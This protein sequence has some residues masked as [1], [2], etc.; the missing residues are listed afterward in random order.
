MIVTTRSTK[1]P[2]HDMPSALSHSRISHT[3][4]AR[5]PLHLPCLPSFMAAAEDGMPATLSPVHTGGTDSR[6]HSR[7]CLC[8]NT[9]FQAPPNSASVTRTTNQHFITTSVVSILVDALDSGNAGQGLKI[10]DGTGAEINRDDWRA[11][12]RK[13]IWES[14][15]V[16]IQSLIDRR[17]L[18]T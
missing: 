4:I 7:P 15:P 5:F 12:D 18:S 3:P 17:R 1:A 11:I 2:Q 8:A 16:Y 10:L 9:S 13:G 6:C 14:C